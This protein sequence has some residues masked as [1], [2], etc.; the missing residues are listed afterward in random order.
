M[1]YRN[2]YVPPKAYSVE[3]AINAAPHRD[4]PPE[5]Y[6]LNFGPGHVRQLRSSKVELRPMIPSIHAKPLF[7][8]IHDIP[9][10]RNYFR[11]PQDRLEE[12]LYWLDIP[13]RGNAAVMLFAIFVDPNALSAPPPHVPPRP[14]HF[15]DPTATNVT[16]HYIFAGGASFKLDEVDA[17]EG[18]IGIFLFPAYWGSVV[19]KHACSLVLQW[20]ME[21]PSSSSTMSDDVVPATTTDGLGLR[22]V[23]WMTQ[24]HNIASQKLSA[25]LGFKFEGVL[26]ESV[27]TRQ[28][29][30]GDSM[31]REGDPAWGRASRHAWISSVIWEDWESETREKIAAILQT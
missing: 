10:M 17:T 9:R 30:E 15:H 25:K 14:E 5:E 8:H 27:L 13:V 16:K 12:T 4:T 18:E 7:E 20:A 1:R 26:R 2:D 21:L 28:G 3:D 24:I 23:Q 31:G 19:A 6:D 29:Q 22:R 11:M